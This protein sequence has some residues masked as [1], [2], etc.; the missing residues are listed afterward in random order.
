ME[1]ASKALIIAGAILLSILIISLGIMIF[2]QAKG[3]MDGSQ[4][5]QLEMQNFN[6]KFTQYEGKSVRGS[7]VNSMLQ[8]VVANNMSQD[9]NSRKV[10]VVLE[11][12]CV[13]GS[14]SEQT[15]GEDT[16]QA[17]KVTTGST[18]EVS[19]C[20]GGDNKPD[21]GLVYAILVNKVGGTQPTDPGQD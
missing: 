7:T 16:S 13:K 14:T 19:C 9:D 15:Q 10:K 5:D 8:A 12:G 2:N 1:N 11:A 4:M 3:A 21:K 17:L 20:V 6:A 18:Y